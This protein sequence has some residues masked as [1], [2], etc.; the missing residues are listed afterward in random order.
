MRIFIGIKASDKLQKQIQNWQEKHK[1]LPVRFIKPENLHITLIP[2]WHTQ[3]IDKTIKQFKK[4]EW[5]LRV[6]LQFREVLFAPKNLPRLI[7]A[8]GKAPK[9]LI[10]L[11]K[12]LH[13][14][15]K[16]KMEKR[17][18]LSHITL[19]RFK[20]F[21]FSL[22]RKIDLEREINWEMAVQ[23]I[24]LFESKLSLSGANYR[25]ISSLPI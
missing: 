9:D 11:R 16:F 14:H 3:R 20:P 5:V 7:W 15:F 8:E 22:I 19:A 17:S 4:F 25:I 1:D 21:D 6:N 12:S 13:E 10:Y 2:P 23:E 18:Y 24:I